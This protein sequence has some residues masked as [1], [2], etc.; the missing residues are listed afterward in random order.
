MG[1]SPNAV[2]SIKVF[3]ILSNSHLIIGVL[4]FIYWIFVKKSFSKGLPLICTEHF[5]FS[6][7]RTVLWKYSTYPDYDLAGHSTSGDDKLWFKF[8]AAENKSSRPYTMKEF[9]NLLVS[10][11]L[12]IFPIPI[13]H[14]NAETNN[15]FT[16]LAS[17]NW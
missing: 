8:F 10:Q 6:V 15:V 16:A 11:F 2:T 17:R 14:R 3:A 4:L 12:C 9:A 7:S 1:S 13:A 5:L